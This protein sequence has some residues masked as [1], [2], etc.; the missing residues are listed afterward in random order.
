[1][2]NRTGIQVRRTD[3]GE[4]VSE[5]WRERVSMLRPRFV[6]TQPHLLM[7]E[8]VQSFEPFALAYWDVR[9]G[10]LVKKVPHDDAHWGLF[11]GILFAPDWSYAVDAHVNDPQDLPHTQDF[12]IWDPWTGEILYES[13]KR[14]WNVFDKMFFFTPLGKRLWPRLGHEILDMSADGKYLLVAE[15]NRIEVWDVIREPKQ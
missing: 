14:K 9:S 6:P 2:V 15:W 1:M 12:I 10:E 5:W 3:T 8:W 4:V 7:T 11:G 13:P